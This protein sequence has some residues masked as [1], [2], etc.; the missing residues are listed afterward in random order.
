MTSKKVESVLPWLLSSPLSI[1]I[2]AVVLIV[3]IIIGVVALTVFK[4]W[5]GV[6]MGG[7]LLVVVWTLFQTKALPTEKYP[8]ITAIL[9]FIPIFGFFFGV[10]GERT[11]VFYVTPLM[12]QE[13][14]IT[15]YYATEPLTYIK[16]NMGTILIIILMICIALAFARAKE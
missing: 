8:W 5:T 11:G 7:V 9:A 13:Q 6:I 3:L 4:L 12:E 2:V 15:P 1:A 14:L 10:W 16:G